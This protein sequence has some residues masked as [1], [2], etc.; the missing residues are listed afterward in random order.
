M[1]PDLVHLVAEGGAPIGFTLPLGEYIEKQW[2]A[3]DL[4][5]V[6]EDGTPWH[7]DG[8]DPDTLAATSDPASEEPA[9]PGGDDVEGVPVR[10][11]DSAHRRHWQAYAVA[12]GACTKD[13]ADGMTKAQLVELVTPPEELPPGP[14]A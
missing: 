11:R 1:S 13:E 12:L 2:R 5:R 9:E 14:E 4:M 6:H 10:P 8:D 3:G 7:E